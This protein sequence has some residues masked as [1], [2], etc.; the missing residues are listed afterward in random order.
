MP[1]TPIKC[2]CVCFVRFVRTSWSDVNWVSTERGAEEM[3]ICENGNLCTSLLMA[4]K[5]TTHARMCVITHLAIHD[6]RPSTFSFAIS[7]ITQNERKCQEM[8]FYTRIRAV[9]EA[10]MEDNISCAGSII[11]IAIII[12]TINIRVSRVD[13]AEYVICYLSLLLCCIVFVGGWFV[14]GDL[15]LLASTY[16]YII[17]RIYHLPKNYHTIWLVNL[18]ESSTK[19]TLKLS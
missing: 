17:M 19:F 8:E 9:V 2:V 14:G 3:R 16:K 7:A 18:Y 1:L 11:I 12:I 6:C 4:P 13:V 10:A 15:R 5:F